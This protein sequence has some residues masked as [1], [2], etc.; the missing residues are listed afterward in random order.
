MPGFGNNT[1]IKVNGFESANPSIPLYNAL[2]NHTY[3]PT[4]NR[5][6]DRQNELYSNVVN[7][8]MSWYDFFQ[9]LNLDRFNEIAD[10]N[11]PLY[12]AFGSYLNKTTPRMRTNSLLALSMANGGSYGGSQAIANEKAK[13]FETQRQ[14]SINN[15]VNNSA[16]G[17]QGSANALLSQGQGTQMAM[18]QHGDN[19]NAQ[20]GNEF[21]DTIKGILGMGTGAFIGSWADSLFQTPRIKKSFPGY[22]DGLSNNNFGDTV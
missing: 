19:M 2:P 15:A 21:W 5:Y 17:M 22:Y 8:S 9:Q 13:Q 4:G 14:D 10:F 1:S 6:Q 18:Q 16:L 11:S 12:K 20:K 7:G 3:T